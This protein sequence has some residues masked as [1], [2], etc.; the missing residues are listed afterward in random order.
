MNWKRGPICKCNWWHQQIQHHVWDWNTARGHLK[1]EIV[2]RQMLYGGNK[3]SPAKQQIHLYVQIPMGHLDFPHSDSKRQCYGFV[4]WHHEAIK[5]KG[6]A[7][8]N[9]VM[10]CKINWPSSNPIKGEE[11]PLFPE[12]GWRVAKMHFT[13]PSAARNQ[14]SAAENVTHSFLFSQKKIE[15]TTMI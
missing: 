13:T 8:K 2:L 14:G 9:L 1:K 7:E 5:V 10:N 4:T 6:K 12:G 11:Y 15:Q 3:W